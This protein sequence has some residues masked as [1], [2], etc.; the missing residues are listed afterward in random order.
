MAR[1]A[2]KLTMTN[3]ERTS[4]D[5]LESA[6]KECR[7]AALRGY[8]IAEENLRKSE[9]AINKV[10]KSLS[11]CLK[12]LEE[13]SVRTEDIVDQ[14]KA[15]FSSVVNELEQL[16]RTLGS[17][18]EERHKRLDIFS[19]TLFGRTLAGKSTLMEILTRGD[20]RSIGTGAQRTTR[21]IRRY[22]WNG[23]EV[24]DVPGVAA[25]EG[26][27]DE[28]LAFKAASQADL[29][30]FLITDD[31]PQPVEAECLARV[32]RLGKPVLGICNVKMAVDDDDDLRIFL[33]NSKRVFNGTR[34]EQLIDQ[35]QAFADQYL[36]GKRVPFV[37]T[38]LRSRF[39]AQQPQYAQQRDRLLAASRFDGIE[40][41]IV[42][43]VVGRGSFLRIKSF[44]DGAVAPMMDITE[45]LLEFS[46]QNSSSGRVLTGKLRQLLKWSQE[47]RTH[48]KKRI[49][50]LVSK[51]M[52]AL[53]DEVPSF[54]ED[55]Y[56]DRSAGKSWKRVVESIGINS[57][58]KKLQ[59]EL[60][61]ECKKE[62]REV[63]REL[64]SELSLVVNLSADR[65][66]QMDAIFDSKRAWNWGTTI[67]AGGL[68]IAAIII[69]SGPLGWAPAAVV[70]VGWLFSK[71]FDDREEKARRARKK[72]T[73]RLLANI[74]KMERE[75]RKSIGDW[76]HQ[77]LL[78]K[79][80]DVYL[81]NLKAVKSIL[82][83][84]A[85]AQRTLAWTLNDRQKA[86]ARTL[87]EEA[88]VQLKAENLKDSIVDIARVPGLATMFLIKPN[89][90]F[91]GK[92]R[93]GLEHLLGEQIWFVVN[94]KSRLSILAQAIGCDCDRN[95]ISIEEKNR[96]AH[97]PIDNLG[98]E[99]K[100]RLRLA[101]QLTGL[102]VMR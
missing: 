90:K 47:F 82:F 14:L 9:R 57:K 56:E 94:T 37:V 19:V 67:L 88:L 73:R 7:K 101:Q 31:A 30:L 87:V 8:K 5:G 66:I 98:P 28:E 12:S 35:F 46:A 100:A 51:T 89:K 53:R 38:H 24:T 49:N 26:A 80:V 21:D 61:D 102:H 40:S 3:P 75:L 2:R 68:G 70:A 97:V 33:R 99:A 15:Q 20:G 4:D 60:L 59:K 39:L 11:Q 18:L 54:A 86:L 32:R 52:D 72:L 64:K 55:H 93:E 10:S 84:L 79:Q 6:L 29:V 42:R 50:T 23:L 36:P 74:D 92:V 41:S 45:R 91:P 77:E 43:E 34:L 95:K 85:G 48:G 16:Q 44:I 63:V 1:T 81:D 58:V 22:Y 27:E 13:G 76:F 78:K 25:F 69:S 71:F 17:E 62:L 83:K 96:V 65:H